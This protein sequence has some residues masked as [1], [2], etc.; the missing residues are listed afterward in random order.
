[1]KSQDSSPW[2]ILFDILQIVFW[3]IRTRGMSS[4][5]PVEKVQ[6]AN[7]D[8]FDPD[9]NQILIGLRVRQKSQILGFSIGSLFSLKIQ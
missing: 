8:I 3:A 9:R 4:A 2:L 1:M 7:S 6:L 5:E